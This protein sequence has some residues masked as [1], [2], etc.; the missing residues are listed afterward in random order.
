MTAAVT[1]GAS[2]PVPAVPARPR[3]RRSPKA[4][5]RIGLYF[6][7]VGAALFFALP[8]LIMISTSLKTTDEIRTGS[9]FLLPRSLDVSAWAKAWSSACIG[10][11]CDGIRGGFWNSIR[12]M[13]PSTALSVL[14]SALNGYALS[15]WRI[16][17]AG[18]LLGALM[19][20]AFIPYQVLIYPLVRVSSI[21]GLYGSVPAVVMVHVL[22][23]L[24]ILTLI[25]HNFYLSLPEELIKAAR[26]DGAGFF[27]IFFKIILPMSTNVVIVTLILSVT[28]VW[29]DYLL[30]LVFAGRDNLPMT[31]EL[32]SMVSTRIGVP[33]YNVN[34]AAT[35][36]TAL[37][38]L[39]LYVVSGRSFVSGVTAGAV[40]G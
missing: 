28:G 26:V 15:L 16:R 18:M 12:I 17:R 3:K 14:L 39:L 33:E 35:I 25:F 1:S 9:I 13:V 27:R 10:R 8:L 23:G 5:G 36:I 29:N 22:F 7:L 2:L 21:M 4:V 11:S 20:G 37:P 40:K 19:V 24:P 34:M 32:A 31:V 6:F 30:S 38:P